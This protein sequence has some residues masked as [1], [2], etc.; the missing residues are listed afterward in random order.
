M[1]KILVTG[2]AGYI[3]SHVVKALLE[4]EYFVVTLDNLSEGH[5]EAVC[6]GEFVHGDLSDSEFL[7]SVFASHQFD[8][9]MHFAA[10]CYVGESVENPEKYYKNNVTNFLNLLAST[11]KN[12]VKN[13]IFSSTAAV[14][15]TPLKVP[16]D[17]SHLLQP[18]NPYGV[19]KFVA[20]NILRDYSH[21]Y[22]LR[23]VSLRYFNAA[24]ADPSGALGESHH[25]E[26]H[27][28]PRVLAVAAGRIP[29]VEIFG[30]DYPTQDGTC[31]RDYI[32]VSDLA[33]AHLAALEF[34]ADRG[35]NLI[36]NLGNG[37]GYSVKEIIRISEQVVGQKI[38]VVHS[39]RREGDPAVLVCD[40]T[41]A[42]EYLHWSPRISS[43]EEIIRTAWNWEQHRRF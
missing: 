34:L 38:G 9:V 37:R 39:P 24:G 28:I 35:E 25:P 40:N 6:G 41:R 36:V 22:G 33:E 19:T 26:P 42:R 11:R 32:H 20:E 7:E 21:S 15:G 29:H 27:L 17:E 43:L 8:S 1:K 12:Q 30:W 2:G 3:G 31:I 10:H 14:Y 13:I 23:F 4:A 16:I 18:I 5:R